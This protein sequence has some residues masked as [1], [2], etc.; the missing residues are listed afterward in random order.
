MQQ[1]HVIEQGD[2]S[3]DDYYSA[4]DRL[5]GSLTSMVNECTA[6]DCPAHKFIEKFLTYRF[7]MGV[8]P[9]FDSIRTRLLHNSSTLTMD[10]ALAELLA[11]ETRLQSM[12]SLSTV[13]MPHS[14]LAA[15][16]RITVPR[17]TSSEPCKHCGKTTHLSANCFSAYPEKLAE[18]R[19]RRASRA[20]HGRGTSSTA[21][22]GS[23]S[24]AAASS[25]DASQPAWVLDSGA[26][27][28][29]TSD[30]SQLVTCKPITD[31]ASIQTADGSSNRDCDWD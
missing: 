25:V 15:S 20:A 27:F 19:A 30:Q 31:G 28:H 4:Y 7:V 14:V 3:I 12:S 1:I 6:A 21:R 13:T 11:E 29:V 18:Y 10:Q 9:E 17:G 8:K 22:D 16:Q 26:S 24:V 5:M 2:M 23:V